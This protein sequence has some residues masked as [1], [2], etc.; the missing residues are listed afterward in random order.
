MWVHIPSAGWFSIVAST[1]G[2]HLVVRA[3]VRDDLKRL[4]LT[5]G[6][7]GSELTPVRLRR[8]RHGFPWLPCRCPPIGAISFASAVN[9]INHPFCRPIPSARVLTRQRLILFSGLTDERPR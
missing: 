9:G 1:D 5:S 7:T 4:H 3:R 2:E 6:A 8:R